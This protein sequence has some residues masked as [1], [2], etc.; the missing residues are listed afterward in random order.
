MQKANASLAVSVMTIL[1]ALAT[2]GCSQR[3]SVSELTLA[4]RTTVNEALPG[5]IAWEGHVEAEGV[6]K[7][8]SMPRLRSGYA[9][10]LSYRL[11]YFYDLWRQQGT[12]R[13]GNAY[14]WALVSPDSTDIVFVEVGVGGISGDVLIIDEWD[15]VF[16]P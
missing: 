14:A 8:P 2:T 6:D 9:D 1:L 4:F 11:V 10:Y 12:S 5:E 7:T 13:S 3:E 15:E 16:L